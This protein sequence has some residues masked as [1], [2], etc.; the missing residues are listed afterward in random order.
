MKESSLSGEN[1]Y[2]MIIFP[3]IPTRDDEVFFSIRGPNSFLLPILIFIFINS[4]SVK[5]LSTDLIAEVLKPC[6]P[7][8]TYGDKLWANPLKYCLCLEV[9]CNYEPSTMLTNPTISNTS[10]S[11]SWLI[12]A[13]SNWVWEGIISP[14]T[15]LTNITTSNILISLSRFKLPREDS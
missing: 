13:D 8:I 10:I 4:W 9:N 7:I 6:F 2:K 5:A 11:E 14:R 3:I 1:L 12:S 15:I